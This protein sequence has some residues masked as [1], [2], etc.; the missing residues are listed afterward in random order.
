MI[1][2]VNTDSEKRSIYGLVLRI[3][4]PLGLMVFVM[5]IFVLQ[6]AMRLR[7]K[8]PTTIAA[9]NILLK[10]RLIITFLVVGFYSYRSISEDLMTIVSCIR[11]DEPEKAKA[12]SYDDP[13]TEVMYSQ[14]SIANGR[15]WTED[16]GI[17]C[18]SRPHTYLVGF[19]GV[20]GIVLFLCGI[21]LYLFVFLL[22]QK[23]KGNLTN[24]N[25]LN[26]YGFIY[27]NYTE[28]VVYWEVV[29]LMR[30][31]LIGAV[32][33]F[34]YPLGS[35]LQGIMALGILIVSLGVHLIATPFRYFSLNVLEALSLM[36]SIFTFYSGVV[37]NDENTTATAKVF[38][39]VLGLI[40]NAILVSIFILTIFHYGDKYITAKLRYHGQTN[41]PS[42]PISRMILL[43]TTL[44]NMMQNRLQT[45]RSNR[46][47]RRQR[48]NQRQQ[49]KNVQMQTVTPTNVRA[50]PSTPPSP[51]I[52]TT[53]IQVGDLDEQPS[54]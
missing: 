34:A 8:R 46:P 51:N 28:K 13:G 48:R 9:L 3:A 53:V 23:S 26:T 7:S 15:Y 50:V 39:S 4:F 19:L 27:Q 43:F 47:Q 18:N 25:V 40:I 20:P 14:Y 32:V 22:V 1:C 38:L 12:Y 16:T 35:N 52:N 30:K 5:G 17:K 21:P 24:L 44:K 6:W 36:V 49:N 54:L 11:L 45:I 10:S 29:I 37:F 33:V 41:I 2:A 31:A 42:N